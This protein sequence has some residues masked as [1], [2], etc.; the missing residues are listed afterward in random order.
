VLVGQLTIRG[1][2]AEVVSLGCRNSGCR[3]RASSDY[4]PVINKK[5]VTLQKRIGRLEQRYNVGDLS[6]IEYITGV[7]QNLCR[8]AR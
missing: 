2:M 7:S 5:Y 8:R 6:A 3:T 1:A 4:S